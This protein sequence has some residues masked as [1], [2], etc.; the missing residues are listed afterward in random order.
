V[1]I[2]RRKKL[3][4]EYP[5]REQETYEGIRIRRFYGGRWSSLIR[6]LRHLHRNDYSLIQIHSFGLMEDLG[7][8]CFSHGAPVVLAH[9]AASLPDILTRSGIW[10]STFRRSLRLMDSLG[11]HFVAFT[12]YQADLYKKVGLKSISVIPHAMTLSSFKVPKRPLLI[13]E[14]LDEF[15][16]LHVGSIEPRKG[17]EILIRCMPSLLREYPRTSLVLVGKNLE[18]PHRDYLQN[19][20]RKLGIEKHVHFLRASREEL[21]QLYLHSDLFAFP[22]TGEI[23]GHVYLEAMAAG[24]P[25][26][27]TDKPVAREILQDGRAGMLV[28]R[29]VGAFER[30]ILELMGDPEL[31]RRLA[32]NARRAVEQKFE[33]RKILRKWWGLYRSLI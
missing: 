20:C 24:C 31:R 29:S 28:E 33:L 25:V 32:R 26:I 8:A 3:A 4:A 18:S 22:T 17:Q 5:E 10:P 1:E 15:N 2:I 27:T 23:F 9:H 30:G 13:S 7:A 16:I 14:Y 21:I 6:L 11:V 19:L 12:H